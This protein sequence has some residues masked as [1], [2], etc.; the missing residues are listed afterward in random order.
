MT[1]PPQPPGP[2][3]QQP[4]DPNQPGPYGPQQGPYNQGPYQQGPYQQQGPYNQGPWQ[5]DPWAPGGFPVGPPPSKPRTGLITALIIV[6]IL[7]I[8][9]GAVGAYFLLGDEGDPGAGSG[10]D[11]D[12]SARAAAQT[13]VR[14]LEKALNTEI[15]DVDLAPLKPVTCR[16]DFTQME[17]D[18]A[19]A[20]EFAE[21]YSATPSP[22]DRIRI[23][24]KDFERT[25][26]GATFL[27]T[28]RQ[29]GDGDEQTRNM[30]V[31]REDGEWRVCGVYEEGSEDGSEDGSSTSRE[32]PPNPIP[33]S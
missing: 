4:P 24:M 13:Y 21:S 7:V 6:S 33:T 5:Q 14:E 2:Y 19:D 32:V 10:G 27:L 22:G 8:G 17:D 28:E 1:Y 29:V 25:S 12:R 20:K 3:G 16:D 31:A 18:I 23:R 9:G 11:E 26:E 15:A 30:T